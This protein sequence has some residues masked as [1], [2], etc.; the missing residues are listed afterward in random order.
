[1]SK[2]TDLYRSISCIFHVI[3]CSNANFTL[4]LCL[5][6]FQGISKALEVRESNLRYF[7][8][9]FDHFWRLFSLKWDPMHLC[10]ED[11]TFS[12][13][14]KRRGL[15]ALLMRAPCA[16]VRVACHCQKAMWSRWASMESA[17]PSRFY[18]DVFLH[19]LCG[20]HAPAQ[21]PA[22]LEL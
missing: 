3:S 19:D 16:R 6:I 17:W 4:V 7:R 10:T 21:V 11:K 18:R 15:S 5:I 13:K 2:Y 22:C 9:H 12:S 20:L 14:E 8:S 1:M